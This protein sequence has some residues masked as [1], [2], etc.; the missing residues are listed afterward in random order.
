[1]LKGDMLVGEFESQGI[2]SAQLNSF[3]ALSVFM[4][5]RTTVPSTDPVAKNVPACKKRGR[6]VFC[7][8]MITSWTDDNISPCTL[9]RIKD[10]TKNL[11]CLLIITRKEKISKKIVKLGVPKRGLKQVADVHVVLLLHL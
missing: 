1:M 4:D 7:Q 10:Y 5:Q 2:P 9:Y 6:V 8:E 3:T 11:Y